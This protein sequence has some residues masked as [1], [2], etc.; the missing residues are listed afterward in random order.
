M[1]STASMSTLEVVDGIAV[2]RITGHCR[3][4]SAVGLVTSALE[5]ARDGRHAL[6]LI[7]GLQ[8]GG[9]GPPSVASRLEM[10]R[11]WADAAGGSVVCALVV[12]PEWIDHEKIGI[13][14]ARNRGFHCDVFDVEDD[15][16]AWL[17]AHA[18]SEQARAE[19]A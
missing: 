17:L 7:E 12:R 2:L 13:I 3:F 16:R 1:T 15:A 14:A 11:T 6:C 19:P 8:L 9:F 10:V 18:A 4:G 5:Q